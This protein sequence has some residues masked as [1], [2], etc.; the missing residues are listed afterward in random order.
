MPIELRT[1]EKNF[2]YI[3][4]VT[5]IFGAVFNFFSFGGCA[6]QQKFCMKP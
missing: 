4:K 6:S 5:V 3:N 2:K 1:S